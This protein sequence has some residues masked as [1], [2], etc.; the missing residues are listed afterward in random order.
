MAIKQT[1]L[2]SAS[3]NLE[4]D[5]LEFPQVLLAMSS[6][7]SFAGLG[8]C[9]EVDLWLRGSNCFLASSW[10]VVSL[11]VERVVA[12]WVLETLLFGRRSFE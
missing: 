10:L 4:M 7:A 12:S 5:W 3:W 11:A 9:L 2:A 6:Q 8:D 1:H